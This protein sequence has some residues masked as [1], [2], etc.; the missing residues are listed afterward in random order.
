MC[1][2]SY[3]MGDVVNQSVFYVKCFL[4]LSCTRYTARMLTFYNGQ[5]RASATGGAVAASLVTKKY[6]S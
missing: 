3:K 5:R 4:E 1:F 6:W 2:L